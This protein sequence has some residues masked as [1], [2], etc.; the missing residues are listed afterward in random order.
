MSSNLPPPDR[1]GARTIKNKSKTVVFDNHFVPSSIYTL[2]ID[3]NVTM[4]AGIPSCRIF[5]FSK[6]LHKIPIFPFIAPVEGDPPQLYDPEQIRQSYAAHSSKE[7]TFYSLRSTSESEDGSILLTELIQGRTNPVWHQPRFLRA[8]KT[9]LQAETRQGTYSGTFSDSDITRMI[10]YPLNPAADLARATRLASNNDPQEIDEYLNE[11]GI[12]HFT[13]ADIRNLPVPDKLFWLTRF[14]GAYNNDYKRIALVQQ[15]FRAC[16]NDLSKQF[17]TNVRNSPNIFNNPYVP[18]VVNTINKERSY[19]PVLDSL[20]ITKQDRFVNSPGDYLP[21]YL[22]GTTA[23]LTLTRLRTINQD[24][25]RQLL[26]TYSD[27]EI[28]V[29]LGDSDT[30]TRSEF[31]AAAITRASTRG[32][33]PLQFQDAQLCRNSHSTISGREFVQPGDPFIGRGSPA[34]G[35]YCYDLVDLVET[36]KSSRD[37]EGFYSFDDPEEYSVGTSRNF[38]TNEIAEIVRI[39]PT[40]NVPP[41]MVGQFREFLQI[42]RDQESTDITQIRLF[43]RWINQN[44]GN[45]EIIK[46]LWLTYFYMGMYMRQWKGPGTPYPVLAGETGQEAT[47][48]SQLEGQININITQER[49]AFLDLVDQLPAELQELLWKLHI[50][51]FFREDT[52]PSVDTN[53]IQARYNDVFAPPAGREKMCIRMASGPWAYTGAYYYK[54]ILQEDIPNFNLTNRVEYIQ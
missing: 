51:K 40:M 17:V 4:F 12:D 39:L 11:V 13:G 50:R 49:N 52:R 15:L 45:R 38:T 34:D 20:G 43:R 16:T 37:P 19:K 54:Q 36:F 25:L 33:F 1:I 29:I 35:F 10:N 41:E 18:E 14:Y 24:E 7:E 30:N 21:L 48:G 26:E 46:Q 9:A 28:V 3:S 44:P 8:I 31:I 2:P 22:R 5:Y 32:I 53:T 27:K 42:A 23:P 47:A 6:H